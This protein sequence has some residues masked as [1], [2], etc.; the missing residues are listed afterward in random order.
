MAGSISASSSRLS[1]PPPR[2]ALTEWTLAQCYEL[3]FSG[4][5]A[6]GD[7]LDVAELSV[8]L[9]VSR[10]PLREALHRLED[11]G[12]VEASPKNGRKRVIEFGA[13][14]I[15]ELYEVR[16]ALEG[17]ANRIAADRISDR[18]LDKLAELVERMHEPTPSGQGRGRDFEADFQFHETIVRSADRQRFLRGL[19]PIWLETR[20][21][22]RQLDARG[23]YPG[24][25]ELD[26]VIAEHSRVLEAL[27]SR[28]SQKASQAMLDH[29]TNA[30][31]RLLESA[32]EYRR[33]RPG[34]R[35]LL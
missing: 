10:S 17:P 19:T 12:L 31:R 21:L 1:N 29:L 22:L 35:G 30:G 23:I 4:Q 28:D 15:A 3:I 13:A 9:G 18:D 34:E 24:R 5:A 32:L 8:R 2:R 14:D 26:R 16:A 33:Q 6:P 20:A 25:E 7:Y 27:R 11:D